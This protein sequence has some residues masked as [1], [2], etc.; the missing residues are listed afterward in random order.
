V[1]EPFVVVDSPLAK[2]RRI[3]IDRPEQSNAITPPICAALEQALTEADGD[4]DVHVVLIGGTGG[5]SFCGGYDLSA[6]STGIR[7]DA[8]QSM[9]STVRSVRIPTVALV[10]GHAVGAGLD[11]AASCDL[12]VVRRGSKI[13]LPAVRIGVAYASGGL[14]NLVGRFPTLRRALLTGELQLGEELAGFADVLADA[15]EFDHQAMTLAGAIATAA[16]ASEAYMVAMIRPGA[17]DRFDPAESLRWRN[18]ILDSAD[19]AESARAREAGDS[20]QFAPRQV[21]P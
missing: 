2:V 3:M 7:D 11:L 10:N 5:R 19:P 17:A 13:G 9:L 4:P 6:V 8:L 16:P 14:Q 18:E 15:D 12:R 20:P 21:K 1:P